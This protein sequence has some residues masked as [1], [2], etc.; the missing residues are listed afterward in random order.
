MGRMNVVPWREK[1]AE[2]MRRPL[3]YGAEP[4]EDITVKN[5]E[6]WSLPKPSRSLT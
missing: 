1:I 2:L 4:N 6:R 3:L 5:H